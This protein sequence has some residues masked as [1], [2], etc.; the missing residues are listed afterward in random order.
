MIYLNTHTQYFPESSPYLWVLPLKY[1][2]HLGQG[3]MLVRSYN[4]IDV[5]QQYIA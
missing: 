5:V 1:I 2:H 3:L 4:L